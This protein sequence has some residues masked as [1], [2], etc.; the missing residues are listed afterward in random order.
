M[1]IIKNFSKF[2]DILTK[3]FAYVAVVALLFN[4]VI[5]IVNVI[6][7]AFGS[8]VVGVE[9]Y[10]SMSEV[11]LIFL[12]LGYTQFNK[13]LVHVCFFMKKLPKRGP[14]IMWAL[15]H[16][17]SVGVIG[18]IVWQTFE[19][20]PLAKQATTALLIPFKPFYVIL[21]IGC[22]VYGI[23]QLFE[24]VKASVAIFNAE[25]REE[26]MAGLPA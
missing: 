4:V 25:V 11:V 8:A 17:I 2:T 24:A 14:I 10:V 1:K 3:L 6:M 5:I 20:I 22:I 26:V 9:E 18:L 16:W 7:R 15:C 12:A 13:G 19:R 21:L 23:A